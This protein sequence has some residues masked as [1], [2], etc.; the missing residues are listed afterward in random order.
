MHIRFRPLGLIGRL[1]LVLIAAVVIDTIGSEYLHLRNEAYRDSSLQLDRTAERLV[2]GHRVLSATEPD[3]RP[4]IARALSTED[5]D[6]AW[7]E[8]RSTI[9]NGGQAGISVLRSHLVEH[10]PEL[11]GFGLNLANEEDDGNRPTAGNLRLTDGSYLHFRATNLARRPSQ[12]LDNLF[13]TLVLSA[14]VLSAA[15]IGMRALGT[16]LRDLARAANGLG[17]G[18]PVPVDIEGP[19]EVRQLAEAFNAMQDRILRMITDRTH[20]L[21]AVSHDLRTPIAR[22]RLRTELLADEELR[23]TTATDLAD[24]ERMIDSV[25]AYL[26]GDSD[27]EKPRP[28]DL[29]ALLRTLLDEAADA[30]WSTEY[31]GP[32]QLR[33]AVR[34]LSLKRALSNLIENALL[35]CGSV[36]VCVSIDRAEVRISVEDE[37]PGIPETDLERAFE[38]FWRLDQSR[39]R[40]TGGTGLGLAIARQAIERE[41]G[42]ITL[43]NRPGGGLKV[44]VVLLQR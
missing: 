19:R 8:D 29:V 43:T 13:T 28:V 33:I 36:R 9:A 17:Q 6:L 11:E 2:L 25:L 18:H 24:M 27:P 30:G 34:P 39:G 38:P 7:S 44:L 12:L 42:H 15:A 4:A 26:K 32:Q 23:S 37:G 21:A 16:P 31:D 10:R 3:R 35:Y 22:L 41:G 1:M 40:N 20:A 5:L 14:G